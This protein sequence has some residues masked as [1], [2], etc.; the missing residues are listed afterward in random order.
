VEDLLNLSCR[1]QDEFFVANNS[2]AGYLLSTENASSTLPGIPP[3]LAHP[4]STKSIPPRWP[5]R[6]ESHFKVDKGAQVSVHGARKDHPP[7][8]AGSPLRIEQGARLVAHPGAGVDQARYPLEISNAGTG[9]LRTCHTPGKSY[10]LP[11]E[12]P[13]LFGFSFSV[14]AGCKF[15]RF[16]CD[17]VRRH[18]STVRWRNTMVRRRNTTSDTGRRLGG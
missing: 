18:T 6:V 4:D 3:L 17:P 8:A 1:L 9:R 16:P 13:C 5:I 12:E 14:W 10:V 15:S 11:T 7:N 2:G